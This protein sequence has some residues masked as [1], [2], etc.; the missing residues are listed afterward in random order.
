MSDPSFAPAEWAVF[1][2]KLLA[3]FRQNQ[4]DYPWRK[5]GNWFHLL[6]AEMMLRR[7]RADQVVPVYTD[8]TTRFQSPAE[9]AGISREELSEL[10]KPLGLR[11]R[12]DQLF[13]TI[14]YLK[15]TYEDN[16]APKLEL[17]FRQIP[18]IGDYSS[19]MLRNRL[20]DEPVA[21]IDINVA[22]LIARWQGRDYDAE[23]R[24]KAWLKTEANQFVKT[25]H[26]K[27]LNLAMLDFAALVCKAR[28]PDC[29]NC[30]LNK[31]CKTGRAE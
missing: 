2:R 22:R 14:Q 25:K 26:S 20:Y 24:R 31:E 27:E 3:W 19:A 5:T 10:L 12:A 6:M 18:G 21:T 1:R 15:H 11:W 28:K 8:F 16:R 29:E 9:S 17:E 23:S 13:D 30:P 7:T 4:R